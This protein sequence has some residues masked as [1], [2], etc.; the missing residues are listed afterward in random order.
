VND[1]LFISTTF[2]IQQRNTLL[3]AYD[4]INEFHN[5]RLWLFLEFGK[6]VADI[7]GFYRM[8]IESL[9]NAVNLLHMKQVSAQALIT[10]QGLTH[11]VLF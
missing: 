6:I 8:V 5:C 4:N 2:P 1:Y 11:S 10:L 3:L 9:N 7:S